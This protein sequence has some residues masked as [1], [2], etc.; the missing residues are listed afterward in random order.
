MWNSLQQWNDRERVEETRKEWED[1]KLLWDDYKNDFERLSIFPGEDER[2][3]N[4]GWYSTTE[5]TPYI[6]YSTDESMNDS[7]I[8]DG[9][10]TE[11]YKLKGVQYYSNKV[12]IE[13]LKPN[14]DYYFQRTLNG[15]WENRKIH[16][17]TRDPYDFNF[18]F[19]GDPQIG[20][21]HDRYTITNNYERV[22]TVDEGTRNDAFNW[23]RTIVSSFAKAKTPSV[24][25]SAG[26]QADEECRHLGEEG[27]GD[28]E[29]YNEETQYSAFLLPE[30]M[31]TIPV[32]AT[33]GNHDAANSNFRH[34]FFSPNPYEDPEYKGLIP[35]YNY[36]FRHYNVL[37]VVLETNYGSCTDFTHV[38]EEAV[39]KYNTTDWRIA[40]FHHDI[41]GNGVTHSTEPY[42]TDE[43]RPCLTKLFTDNNFDLV[44]NGHD[45][46]YTAS[47]FIIADGEKKY[48]VE[49]I[50]TNKAYTSPEGTLFI[51]ANCSTGSKLYSYYDK[52]P[53]YV[54][55]NDQTFSATFGILDFKIENGI[56]KLTVNTYEVESNDHV[57]DGPYILQKPAKVRIIIFLIQ[58]NK[59]NIIIK[60]NNTN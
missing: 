3:L 56:A 32:A 13:D 25:L 2:M 38:I 34:H 31:Q 45:H 47:K 48:R 20:G 39:A 30:L 49:S 4:F 46:V 18:I 15:E 44:I 54:Y 16:F 10:V 52:D 36:Y 11:H 7:I 59:I 28:E 1:F 53:D 43:L 29:L 14:T 41:Y 19:V 17:K 50:E 24:L 51:T 60:N 23:N 42:L 33:V 21:S 8:K 40:M 55:K 6:K 22:L 58:I 9:T 57:T 5:T 37:V 26:D 12:Y 27:K 35:G